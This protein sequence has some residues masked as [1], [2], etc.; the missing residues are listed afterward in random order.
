MKKIM[1]MMAVTAMGMAMFG[2]GL[3]I[4]AEEST[5]DQ[6][7][8][9]ENAVG[10]VMTDAGLT[11]DAV[12]F[13]KKMQD[14]DDGIKIYEI[15]F[16][17]PGEMKYEYTLDVENRSIL[18][19][20]KEPWEAEDDAEY[21][22]LI[23]EEI[24]YFD[25]DADDVIDVMVDSMYYAFTEAG[26]PDDAVL[27]KLGM[28]YDDG[29]ILFKIGM[30]SPEAGKVEFE[31]DAR[32]NELLTTEKEAWEADDKVVYDKFLAEEAA[33]EDAENGD[34]DKSAPED[35]A[36]APAD[37]EFTDEDAKQTALEDAGFS[38]DEVTMKECHL[39]VDDGIEQFEVSFIGPDGKEYEY[40][41]SAADGQIL[42]KD[43]EYDD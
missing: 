43:A 31:F 35:A 21:Q 29:M 14:Y 41:I 28:E 3:S 13:S 25:Y 10:I 27:C 34:I 4:Y 2:A 7:F 40:E 12:T 8:M 38:E 17:V 30:L 23:N 9:M 11:E 37:A 1:K 33:Y 15:D 39:D 22:N 20:E 16:I 19:Q 32:K 18:A 5:T 36:P 24:N 6:E 42:S 26:L